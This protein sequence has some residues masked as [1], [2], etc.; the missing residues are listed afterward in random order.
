M[1]ASMLLAG[2]PLPLSE[3]TYLMDDDILLRRQ[4]LQN[5]LILNLT[6]MNRNRFY[7]DKY[8]T[9]VSQKLYW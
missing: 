8:V 3:R 2:A 6:M 1:R 4:I 5:H 7:M 9:K